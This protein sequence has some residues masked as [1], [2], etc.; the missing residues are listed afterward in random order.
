MLQERSN[1]ER[2]SGYQHDHLELNHFTNYI[3]NESLVLSLGLRY[4]FREMFN[5]LSTDEFRIIE[6]AEISPQ[7]SV[8]SHRVRLEQRFRKIIIHRLRYELSF[9]RPLG[10]SLDFMAATE[11][12]YAVAAE[13]KPEAEQRFSIGIENTSFK[14]LELGLGFEYRMENYTRQLAHE[15]FLTTELTLNLN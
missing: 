12:L 11:A 3:T 14:D 4:R 10:S 5:S 8:F 2:I 7:A 13:T 9:S 15:F 1:G 6:Q